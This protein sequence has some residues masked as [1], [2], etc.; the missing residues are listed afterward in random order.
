MPGRGAGC[1]TQGGLQEQT[2]PRMLA[3]PLNCFFAY[4]TVCLESLAL[5]LFF[6]LRALRFQL[7]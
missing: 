6:L 2:K 5:V 4:G 3:F 1:H 7:R